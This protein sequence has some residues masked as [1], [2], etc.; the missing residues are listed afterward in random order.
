V[1]RVCSAFFFVIVSLLSEGSGIIQFA[2]FK[3]LPHQGNFNI[4]FQNWV[5]HFIYL[6]CRGA[7]WGFIEP[8][9]D[10]ARLG[11]IIIGAIPDTGLSCGNGISIGTKTGDIA[12]FIHGETYRWP[13]ARASGRT[14]VITISTASKRNYHDKTAK[15]RKNRFHGK[16]HNLLDS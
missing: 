13:V 15:H 3:R 2:R 16:P 9:L 7:H 11:D 10:I 8:E 12:V 4:T 14:A 6:T 5:T 1:R